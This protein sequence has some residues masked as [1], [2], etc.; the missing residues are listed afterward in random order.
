MHAIG[1]FVPAVTK[2]AFVLWRK[3]R[4]ALEIGAGQIVEQHVEFRVEQ[5]FPAL[6]QMIKQ[7][8][9][10]LQNQIVAFVEP[11]KFHQG[12]IFSQ[13]IPHGAVLKPMT[14]QAPFAARSDQPI[15]AEGLHNQVPARAFA[16][17]RQ[18]FGPETIQSQF[19]VKMTKQPA[20]APLPRTAQLN[21]REIKAHRI[22]SVGTD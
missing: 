6:H 22:F 21:L 15:S 4:L 3:G 7:R 17:G 1:P 2:F 8:R 16:A 10:V 13:Q 12:K 5:I 19:L 11:V 9:L 20:R 14:V 18:P